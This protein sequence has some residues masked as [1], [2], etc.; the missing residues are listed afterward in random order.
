MSDGVLPAGLAALVEGE[1]LGHVLVDGAEGEALMAGGLDGHGDQGRV[2]VRR[3]H[4]PKD[5]N[6]KSEDLR[7]I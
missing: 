3:P 1:V 2:R 7:Q 6:K 5:T 4:Q